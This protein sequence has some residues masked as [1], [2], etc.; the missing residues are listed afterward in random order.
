MIF[1]IG[2]FAYMFDAWDVLLPAYLFPLL[3]RSAWHLNPTQLGWLGTSGL[4]GM[5]LGAFVWGT[6]SD[7]VGRRR[8]FLWT[9]MNYSV[10][11][12][13]SAFSPT[14]SVLLV[15]RFIT[16]IGLGG[17]IPVAYSLVAEFM[18][19]KRR[20]M[21]LTAMDVWWPIGGTLNGLIAIVLLRYDSWRVLLLVMGIPALLVFWALSSIPESPLV[22][23]A[24]WT[25]KT[26]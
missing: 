8:A 10:F 5:A 16:G 18:P 26:R 17:C 25:R 14:Y 15:A 1:L 23:H 11:S 20:G 22:P 3:G 4:V 7:I 12:I 6:L 9:L 2:G 19:R 24:A 13:L 21:M